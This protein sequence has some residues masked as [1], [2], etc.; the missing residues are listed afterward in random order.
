MRFSQGGAHK[1]AVEK[2]RKEAKK[3]FQAVD[4][5]GLETHQVFI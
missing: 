4:R 3:A 2:E 1:T 5:D